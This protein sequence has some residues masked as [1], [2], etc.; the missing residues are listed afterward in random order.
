MYPR[1][2]L[3]MLLPMLKLCFKFEYNALQDLHMLPQGQE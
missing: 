2:F 1:A 3:N